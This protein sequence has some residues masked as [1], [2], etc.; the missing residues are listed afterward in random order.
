[1]RIWYRNLDY[2]TIFAWVGLASIGLVAIYSTTNGPSAEYLLASVRQNF[3]R[4]LAWIVISS[5]AGLACLFLPVH[6]FQRIAWVAYLGTLLLLALALLF[7]REVNGARSWLYIGGFSLQVSEIAKVGAVLAAAQLVSSIRPNSSKVRYA[8]LLVAVF[9]VPVALIL[10]Q[11]DAGTALVFCAV[12]PVA[13]FWAIW[14]T[15]M[16]ILMAASGVAGYFA[17]VHLPTALVFAALFTIFVFWKTRSR[18]YGVMA[19]V[20]SGGAVAAVLFAL[21]KVFRP[22]QVARI[23]SF[24]NPGAEE[25]RSGVGF[26]LVQSKAAIGS[27]GLTGKGFMEGTQTQGAY[28]PEQSTD[29]VFSII[30]E[31]WGFLG[32]MAVIA[33]FTVLL[34]RVIQM[35]MQIK[36]PFG[37]MVAVG[38]ASIFL[39][40][41]FVNIGMVAGLLPVIGIPLPFISYG[42]SAMLANTV[43]LAL[44]LNLHMRRDDF[45][46]YVY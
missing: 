39:A 20:F 6:F 30:G 5:G 3:W 15:S 29:F 16:F 9:M 24:T 41:V 19:G 17:V 8:L 2:L 40:H 42:G 14:P 1:M 12:A 34:V 35:G 37:S 31:E 26:H 4:Q 44:L 22:H 28:V 32:S 25:F 7:G 21:H 10:L 36:H 46:I 18:L 33:L 11:N 27:G 43:L 38:T 45:P 23:R 13:V